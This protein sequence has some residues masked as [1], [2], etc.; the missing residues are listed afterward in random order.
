MRRR[1]SAL[2]LAVLLGAC[3]ADRPVEIID[4]RRVITANNGPIEGDEARWAEERVMIALFER[5]FPGYTYRPSTWQYSAETFLAR[6]AGNTAT[7]VIGISNATLGI[8]LAERGLAL[9]ITPWIERWPPARDLNPI[10]MQTYTRDGRVYGLPAGPGYAMCLAYNRQMFREAGLVDA[11]GEP[12]PPDTW[13]EL[14]EWAIRLTD[15][16]RGIYGFAILGKDNGASWHFL[17]WV[18]QA[19]GDF[20]RQDAEG[21]WHAVFD[22]PPAVQALRFLHDLRHR[23][24]VVPENSR[25]DNN[26]QMELFVANRLAMLIF[27]PE[28]LDLLDNRYSYPVDNVGIAMLPAGPAGH[29]CVMGGGFGIINPRLTDPVQIQGA[30]NMLAFSLL[31]EKIDALYEIRTRQGR[32][33]GW[34]AVSVWRPGSEMARRWEAV[35]DRWRNVPEFPEYAEMVSRHARYEPPIQTQQLYAELVAVIQETLTN[36]SADLQG[37]LTAAARRFERRHLF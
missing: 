5:L 14:R 30:F 18:Y 13:E 17:N 7:D 32:P 10:V 22:E 34:P 12:D 15:R 31:P 11:H 19:G 24:R 33:V 25:M 3:A 21:H 36:P 29:A 26:D 35:E 16:E 6:I 28:Y 1:L 9:D 4:G 20:E 8:A 23:D 27:V 2:A 37:L